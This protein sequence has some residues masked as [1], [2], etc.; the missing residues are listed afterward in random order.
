[1]AYFAQECQFIICNEWLTLLRNGGSVCSGIVAH[2]VP[3]YPNHRGDVEHLQ[4]M[5][6]AT[7]DYSK[8]LSAQKHLETMSRIEALHSLAE[9]EIYRLNKLDESQRE[10]ETQK[11]IRSETQKVE[12]YYNELQGELSQGL[13]GEY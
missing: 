8:G 2:Y 9:A 3:Q 10:L 6:G 5:I 13:N 4:S 12:G 7:L 1:M 11:F